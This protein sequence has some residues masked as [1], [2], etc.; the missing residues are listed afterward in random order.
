MAT[1]ADMLLDE[2]LE[3][4]NPDGGWAYGSG[5]SWTEP[6]SYAVLALRTQ[7]VQ[8]VALSR[9]RDWLMRAQRPDGGWGPQTAVP[10]ST[11]VTSLAMLALEGESRR[12][13]IA[14]LAGQTGRSSDFLENLRQTAFGVAAR[15]QD[16]P[17][18]SWFPGTASWVTPTVFSIL[19]LSRFGRNTEPVA[20]RI[21]AG[22]RF[23]LARRCPDGG[24][25][26]GG[27]FFHSE[28]AASY[29]E[30]T[31]MALLGLQGTPAPQV[32][33]SLDRAEALVVQAGSAQGL[34]WLRMGLRAFHRDGSGDRFSYRCYTQ[35][36]RALAV[37]AASPRSAFAFRTVPL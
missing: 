3:G 4:Q 37:L 8:G 11:W 16:P 10:H 19:A 7:Q 21:E 12:D 6:T 2:L 26:H 31:G 25:N 35:T 30:T 36:D 24:W 15:K 27:S 18:W 1:Q 13:A 22:R 29:P 20:E 32:T 34:A 17:G 23:L 28:D 9:A 33:R 5:S 14:W